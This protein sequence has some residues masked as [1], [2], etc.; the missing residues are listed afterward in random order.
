MKKKSSAYKIPYDIRPSKQTERRIILDILK[1]GS[2]VGLK[3]SQ[4]GYVGFGGYRFYDFEMLF[5]HLGIREMVSVEGDRSLVS[6]CNFNKP[7]NFIGVQPG[8]FSQFIEDATFRKPMVAWLDFDSP[9]SGDIKDDILSV[10]A[11]VPIGSFVFVTIDA[12]MPDGLRRLRSRDRVADLREELQTFALNPSEAEVEPGA[13][14]EYADRVLWA[15]LTAALGRR[16]DGEFVP[17]MRVFYR[18][19]TLMITAGGC[20]CEQATAKNLRKRMRREFPFLLPQGRR[21]VP[22]TIPPSNYTSRE[23]HL[24]DATVTSEK[25][26]RKIQNDLSGIGITKAMIADYKRLVRFVPKY[27][28]TYL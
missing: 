26:T 14:P 10:G 1:L 17:L 8:A 7:F 12:R 21:V 18:D 11:K 28:E 19:S 23:R 5:R 6:R 16:R 24:L 3:L 22:Y 20:L 4:Y 13:F 15:I 9:T 2:E 25:V 27:F